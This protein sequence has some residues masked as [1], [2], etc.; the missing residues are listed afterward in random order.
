MYEVISQANCAKIDGRS[1]FRSR[2]NMDTILSRQTNRHRQSDYN[3]PQTNCPRYSLLRS[4][5]VYTHY[6]AWLYF[7]SH[8]GA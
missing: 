6:V 3:N 2:E 4:D 1:V 8:Y 7:H 5:L